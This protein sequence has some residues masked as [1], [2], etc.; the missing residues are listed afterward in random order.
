MIDQL[1]DQKEMNRQP[2]YNKW[3]PNNCFSLDLS[4]IIRNVLASAS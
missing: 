4:K 1:D 2:F 3:L